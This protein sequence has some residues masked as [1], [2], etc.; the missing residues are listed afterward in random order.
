L[1]LWVPRGLSAVII[2]STLGATAVEAP[3]ARAATLVSEDGT[4]IDRIVAVVNAEPITLYELRR[5]AAPYLALERRKSSDDGEFFIKARKIIREALDTLVSDLLVYAVAKQMDITAGP[6]KIDAHIKKL[7]DENGWTEDELA[8]QL[9]KVGFA[10]ISEYRRHA[11][12]EM[13]KSQVLSIKVL[14]RVRVDERD[15]EARYQKEIGTRGTIEERRASHILVLLDET[16]DP[17]KVADS[18]ARL[19]AAR[20][21]IADGIE[22]FDEVAR[23]VSED[24]NKKAGGDLGWFQRGD[25]DPSFDDVIFAMAE[26]ELSE[27]FRSRFG[28]HV[29][30]LTGIRE[31]ELT[32]NEDVETAKRRIR[33][34]LREKE[35]SRVYDQWLRGLRN[36]AFVDLRTDDLE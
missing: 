10:S 30:I 5:A 17:A 1:R 22:T 29:A 32:S 9:K 27:P 19:D 25:F 2:A 16:A 11:E 31:R 23:R 20:K 13:I 7:A 21:L 33:L 12:R 14:S 4:L 15:V 18:Q 6:E 35:L 36:E 8:E 3:S 26:A 34:E 28:M 24:S